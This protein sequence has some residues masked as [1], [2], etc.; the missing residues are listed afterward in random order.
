M[1]INYF[2]TLLTGLFILNSCS[3]ASEEFDDA[4]GDVEE[5][6]I[7]SVLVANAADLS[8]QRTITLNYDAETRLTDVSDGE[9]VEYF[10][11]ENDKLADVS[12]ETGNLSIEELYQSPYNAFEVGDVRVYDS[13]GNPERIAFFSEVYDSATRETRIREY[14][15]VVTYD[16]AP[17]PYFYTLKAAGIIEVLDGVQLEIGLTPQASE[18]VRARALLFMNNPTRL[19]YLDEDGAPLFDMQVD[20]TYNDFNYPT[21]A[22]VKATN[23][24]YDAQVDF[25]TADFTYLD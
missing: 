3:S 14:T 22:N 15:A 6:Y 11:Y 8:D 10:T 19:L 18:L 4:N 7:S 20:Y 25:Y 13:N 23:Y 16:T 17:N 2:F 12:G 21:R 1:K 24:K 5:L 9:T